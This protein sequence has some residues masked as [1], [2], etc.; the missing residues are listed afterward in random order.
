MQ[1]PNVENAM[2]TIWLKAAVLITIG[3]FWFT[4][5]NYN[6]RNRKLTNLREKRVENRKSVEKWKYVGCDLK[7]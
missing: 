4:N 7:K 2:I 1:S 6:I 5:S 3:N